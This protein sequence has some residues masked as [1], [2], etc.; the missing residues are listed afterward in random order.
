M[1]LIFI[2][3]PYRAAT[4]HGI[5][6]NI[7][8]AETAA[9]KCWQMGYAVI[10]PHKNTALL[11]GVLPDEVWLAGDIEMLSRCDAI[12]MMA[13]WEQSTGARAEHEFAIKMGM[14]IIYE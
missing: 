11:D 5:V 3:G 4:V 9:I 6:E 13:G 2:S 1:K 12:Y 14:G 10:C 7:R 8:R